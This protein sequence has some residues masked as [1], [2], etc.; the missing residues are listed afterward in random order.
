M[1]LIT[2]FHVCLNLAFGVT[3]FCFLCVFRNEVVL[4]QTIVG[5]L[6]TIE[7]A[8]ERR[9]SVGTRVRI[10]PPPTSSEFEP[11]LTLISYSIF[12]L[13]REGN[14]YVPAFEGG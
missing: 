1:S 9:G 10:P 14:A 12:S 8:S 2:K 3:N 13:L 4:Q 6:P 7:V 11:S 5:S